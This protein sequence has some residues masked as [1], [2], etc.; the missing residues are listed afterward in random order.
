M[1][2]NDYG[3]KEL[4]IEE[5][6]IEWANCNINCIHVISEIGKESLENGFSAEDKKIAYEKLGFAEVNLR[7]AV[8]SAGKLL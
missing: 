5:A 2:C 6:A 8:K 1:S 7:A 4:T 3:F